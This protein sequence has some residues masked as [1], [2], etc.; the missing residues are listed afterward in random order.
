MHFFQRNIVIVYL[1][2]NI[3]CLILASKIS[4]FLYRE[5]YLGKVLR[6]NVDNVPVGRT[7]TV[8]SDNPFVNDPT[9]RP[10]IYSLGIRNIWR[11]DVDE[12]DPITGIQ[13]L[14]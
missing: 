1:W 14:S 7:Y 3:N 2:S 8:P 6:I 13:Y 12:G 10:E 11:C 5:S 9:T 4:N